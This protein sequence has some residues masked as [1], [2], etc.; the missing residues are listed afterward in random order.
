[1]KKQWQ[2]CQ[3][4]FLSLS[5]KPNFEHRL[6]PPICSWGPFS[7]TKSQTPIELLLISLFS[8]LMPFFSIL[9][10]DSKKSPLLNLLRFPKPLSLGRLINMGMSS[11]IVLKRYIFFVGLLKKRR[12]EEWRS[13][14]RL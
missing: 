1:M 11:N 6:L 3:E 12:F 2:A 4:S 5:R 13:L 9:Y 8:T 14:Q 7:T 10:L